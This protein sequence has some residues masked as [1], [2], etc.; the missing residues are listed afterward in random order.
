MAYGFELRNSSGN[1]ITKNT[2]RQPRLLSSGS[3]TVTVGLSA[4]TYSSAQITGLSDL[5]TSEVDI[6]LFYMWE[7]S[8]IALEPVVVSASTFK[9][10]AVLSS[11]IAATKTIDISYIILRS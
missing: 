11:S 5:N 2:S 4:G 10:Q 6:L 7:W 3:T 8:N 9:V 1:L